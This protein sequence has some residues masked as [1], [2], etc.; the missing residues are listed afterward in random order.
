MQGA[1]CALFRSET[2]N[3]R[4]SQLVKSRCLGKITSLF[5]KK[6]LNAKVS[7]HVAVVFPQRSQQRNSLTQT[8]FCAAQLQVAS[9]ANALKCVSVVSY[10]MKMGLTLSA[11]SYRKAFATVSSEAASECR[12]STTTNYKMVTSPFKQ[13]AW[14]HRP[15]HARNAIRSLEML[16]SERRLKRLQ[17][18]SL[19]R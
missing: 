17:L 15:R 4:W 7:S 19:E 2:E 1:T 10:C 18:F 13:H 9:S 5:A 3:A 11:G 6:Q 14:R 12:Q 8:S 16:L